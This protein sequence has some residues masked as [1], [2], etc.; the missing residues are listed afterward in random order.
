MRDVAGL[1]GPGVGQGHVAM[2]ALKPF[3]E[4]TNVARRHGDCFAAPLGD[5]PPALPQEPLHPGSHGIG[6]R[7]VNLPIEDRP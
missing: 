2:E 3:E 4:Q 1:E 7:L 6:E 5:L